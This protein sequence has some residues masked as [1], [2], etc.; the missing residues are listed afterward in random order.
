MPFKAE[1]PSWRTLGRIW[2]HHEASRFVEAGG[3]RWH[4]QEMGSGPTLLLVHGAGASTHS[5]RDLMPVLAERF[6]VIAMDLPGHAFSSSPPV[7][8]PTL[9]RV[10]AL[11]GELVTVLGVDVR[12]AAG[13]S[14]GAAI[15]TRMALD[16]R[17]SPAGLVSFN[18]A[19]QPFDGAAGTVFPALAKVLFLNPLTPRLFALSGRSRRR[20]VSLIEGT[21]SHLSDEGLKYYQLLMQSP[22]HIAGVLAMMAHWELSTLMQQLCSLKTPLLLIAGE[23]D[24]AVPPKVSQELAERC[25]N[26]QI[27]LWPGLGHLA[28]EEAPGRAADR[29]ITFAQELDVIP[30]DAG[31]DTQK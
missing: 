27:E 3:M 12:L 13:H 9:Q 31:A 1:H 5:W 14:A 8:R 23:R 30:V 4:I 2:P 16:H 17:I 25:A 6:H 21:G 24:R 15:L 28:H 22:G 11:L 7:Y 20:V 29:I 26:A 10:S 19:F 18:G